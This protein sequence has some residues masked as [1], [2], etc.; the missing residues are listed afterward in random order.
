MFENQ[1]QLGNLLWEKDGRKEVQLGTKSSYARN[2]AEK[3]EMFLNE[4]TTMY[5]YEEGVLPIH[6]M[7]LITIMSF[8]ECLRQ[9]GIIILTVKSFA[10]N[11]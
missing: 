11:S 3:R 8:I 2:R 9:M 1:I 10:V 4:C 6:F 7:S 5:C